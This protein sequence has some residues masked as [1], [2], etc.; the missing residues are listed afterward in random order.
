MKGVFYNDNQV[1][2]LQMNTH[3]HSCTH[4]C[5]N[6]HTQ[7]QMEMQWLGGRVLDSRPRGCVALCPWARHINPCLVLVLPRQTRSDI[8]ENYWLGRK[9]SNL[10]N[11]AQKQSLYYLS[12]LFMFLWYH[13]IISGGSRSKGHLL[14]CFW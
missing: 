10:T 3:M 6:S 4:A 1:T 12:N 7:K 14:V 2:L 8:T 13:G 5:I 11:N 9:E